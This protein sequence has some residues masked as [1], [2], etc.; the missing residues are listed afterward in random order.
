MKKLLALA[1][2]LAMMLC[3]VNALALDLGSDGATILVEGNVDENF[4][5]QIV[6]SQMGSS[7]DEQTKAAV[8]SAIKLLNKMGLQVSIGNNG[9]EAD[10]LLNGTA[11][12][13]VGLAATSEG[14]LMLVSDLIPTYAVTVAPETLQQLI[15]AIEQQF[16]GLSGMSLDPNELIN[17][18]LPH[19][20]TLL[21][22]ISANVGEPESGMFTVDGYMFNTKVPVNMT[23]KELATAAVECVK[24]IASEPVVQSLLQQF[25]SLAGSSSPNLDLNTLDNALESIANT[26][27]ENSPDLELAMYS[28][29]DGTY[30]VMDMSQNNE[31]LSLH[32]GAIGNSFVLNVDALGQATIAAVITVDEKAS[33]VDARIDIEAQGQYVGLTAQASQQMNAFVAQLNLFYMSKAAP[34][35]SLRVSAMSGASFTLDLTGAG[36]TA[37]AAEDLINGDSTATNNLMMDLQ[38]YGLPLVLQK[39]TQ[40]MP[41]EVGALLQ[42]VMGQQN[43]Y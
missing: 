39:A 17:A 35:I 6:A 37:L 11:L 7:M 36:K 5:N 25:A 2:A 13:A 23:S 8:S 24:G 43:A 14:G 41:E 4:F 15:N 32:A 29:N 1:L 30:F 33:L 12:A 38:V 10:V 3:C 18:V 20:E 27:D 9:A 22:T 26:P 28:N 31:T 16:G 21:Q 34:I 19:V 40:A 42:M